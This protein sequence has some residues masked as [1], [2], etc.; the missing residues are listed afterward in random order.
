MDNHIKMLG[1]IKCKEDF[2]KFMQLFISTV[3]DSSINYYLEAVAAWAEDM[4][5]YYKNSGEQMPENI[6]WDFIAT[7]LY[8]GSIYE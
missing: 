2:T 1:N 4:D 7:L 3:E 8:A 5:G 6:N